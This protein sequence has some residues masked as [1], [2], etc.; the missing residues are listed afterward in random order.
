MKKTVIRYFVDFTD[1]QEQWLNDMAARGYRLVGCGK[2]TYEFEHCAPAEYQYRVEFIGEKSYA[3]HTDYRRF[4]EGLGY[5]VF[6]KNVNLNW[7]VGKVRLRPWADGAGK[8]ATS[9]GAY[10]K[11]LLIVEKKNDGKPFD[12][13]TDTQDLTVHFKTVRNS[14]LYIAV[15]GIVFAMLFTASIFTTFDLTW[16]FL[17]AWSGSAVFAI[18]GIVGLFFGTKY[19]LIAKRYREISKTNE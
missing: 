5:R 6:A 2:L 15:I 14:Y 10:N 8:A 17:P 9:P 19:A 3:R 18:V 11:E 13:H 16:G 12:L 7:S 4:L 1:K